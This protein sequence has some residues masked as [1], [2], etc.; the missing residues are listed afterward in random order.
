MQLSVLLDFQILQFD[1]LNN[2]VGSYTVKNGVFHYTLLTLYITPVPQ[3]VLVYTHRVFCKKK[4]SNRRCLID[5]AGC[6]AT[7]R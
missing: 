7:L 2:Q 3:K 5:T 1:R 4:L 6:N